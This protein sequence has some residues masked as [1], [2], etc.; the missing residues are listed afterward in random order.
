MIDG[1]YISLISTGANLAVATLALTLGLLLIP[2][3]LLDS[4]GALRL[5]NP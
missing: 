5:R 2:A 4:A 1:S 3:L